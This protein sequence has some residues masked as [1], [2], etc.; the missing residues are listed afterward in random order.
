MSVRKSVNIVKSVSNSTGLLQNFTFEPSSS[1]VQEFA[2]IV[3]INCEKSGYVDINERGPWMDVIVELHN[4]CFKKVSGRAAFDIRLF[5]D[6]AGTPH[7]EY[8]CGVDE[9]R[10]LNMMGMD[11]EELVQFRND[12]LSSTAEAFVAQNVTSRSFR[13]ILHKNGGVLK[14]IMFRPSSEILSEYLSKIC[15]RLDLSN[16]IDLLNSP[17]KGAKLAA[18]RA[19]ETARLKD[20][21]LSAADIKEKV[22]QVTVIDPQYD[23]MLELYY[24]T[25]DRSV[26]LGM[27]TQPNDTIKFSNGTDENL[28]QDDFIKTMAIPQRELPDFKKML[29]TEVFEVLTQLGI[30]FLDNSAHALGLEEPWATTTSTVAM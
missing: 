12:L 23:V 10:F 24:T 2:Q 1:F 21:G 28:Y 6:D 15:I 17:K 7:L 8:S 5:T 18:K 16:F 3:T 22:A 11:E 25:G 29:N 14:N 4:P 30:D 27:Y 19:Q 26:P 9:D 13:I 20:L